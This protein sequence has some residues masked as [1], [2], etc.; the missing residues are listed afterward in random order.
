[1][2]FAKEDTGRD[3]LTEKIIGAAI[4]VHRVLGPGLLECVYEECLCYEL[5]K[6]GLRYE[7]QRHWPVQYKD[8]IIKRGFRTDILVEGEVVVEVKSC[9]KVT[10][11]HE[12]IT[13]TYLRLSKT[14]RALIINFNVYL[15]KDSI[16]R[17][18]A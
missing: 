14:H 11:V 6:M 16:H 10:A 13:T 3:P 4:E 8:R 7:R 1:M 5:E 18:V 12:R 15:L 2:L 17:L 9:E